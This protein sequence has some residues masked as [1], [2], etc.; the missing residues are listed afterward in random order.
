MKS[1]TFEEVVKSKSLSICLLHPGWVQTDMTRQS[2]PVTIPESS[3]KIVE[4]IEGWKPEKNGEF[5]HVITGEIL[6][7]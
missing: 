6:P 2:G 7:W 4:T 5:I 3:G 1:L